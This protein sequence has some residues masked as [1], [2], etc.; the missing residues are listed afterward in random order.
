MGCPD[1]RLPIEYALT[2]PDR[3]KTDFERLRLS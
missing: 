2:Y 3:L 1:M